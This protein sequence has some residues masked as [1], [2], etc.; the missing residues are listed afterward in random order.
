MLTQATFEKVRRKTEVVL[1][2]MFPETDPSAACLLWA[3]VAS[4]ILKTDR[5]LPDGV[6]AMMQAGTA[7]W[8]FCDKPAPEP[9]YFGYAY[10]P[11]AAFERMRAHQAFPEMH[12]WLALIK[13]GVGTHILD[14]SAGCQEAQ[15]HR[16]LNAEW[17][18][19]YCLPP[20]LQITLD[21][22][23]YDCIYRPDP[24]ATDLA[25]QVLQNHFLEQAGKP[26]LPL[27]FIMPARTT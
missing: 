9:L 6:T 25:F 27:R 17:E 18:A 1:G 22:P 21:D 12:V 10:D 7:H 23:K 19:P 14:F 20:V 11:W 15:L 3:G 26:Q 4:A 2:K 5:L 13:D 24:G 16:I 8:R